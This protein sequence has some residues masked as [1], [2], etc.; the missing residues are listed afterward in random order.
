MKIVIQERHGKNHVTWKVQFFARP[1]SGEDVSESQNFSDI[2]S[3]DSKDDSEAN[4]AMLTSSSGNDA[5]R[6]E[7]SKL[8][9]HSDHDAQSDEEAEEQEGQEGQEVI[10]LSSLDARGEREEVTTPPAPLVTTPPALLDAHEL[11][12]KNFPKPSSTLAPHR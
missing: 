6:E 1:N 7:V 9:E 10:S 5:Y 2:D 11:Q 12:R 3:D 4:N 8:S